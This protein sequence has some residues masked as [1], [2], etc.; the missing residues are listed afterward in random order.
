MGSTSSRRQRWAQVPEQVRFRFGLTAVPLFTFVPAVA[1]QVLGDTVPGLVA[2]TPLA[3]V[4]F[5]A[6]ADR[7]M[8]RHEGEPS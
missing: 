6:A 1:G 5:F 3:A 4:I 2:G 8:R 7:L